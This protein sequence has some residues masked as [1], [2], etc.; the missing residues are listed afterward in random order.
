MQFSKG[1]EWRKW[2]LHIHTPLS[3][4]QHYGGDTDEVWEE[5]ISDL[6]R[7]PKEFGAIGINDYLFIDGYKKVIDFK[8]AGRLKNIDLILP[9]LEFRLE[10]FAGTEKNLR[11]INFHVIFSNYI[12][13]ETIQ[14]QFINALSPKY[15]L[16]SG[17]NGIRWSGIITRQSVADLGQQIK[18]SI[19]PDK[20]EQ[21]GSDLEEGFNNLV[22]NEDDIMEILKD[23]SYFNKEGTS[24]YLTAVGKTEWESLKW[25]DA[26][27]ASKKDII[28]K[29]DF[30]FIS[31]ETVD[32]CL[33]AKNKL[34]QHYV[35]D[36]LLDCSD[37]HSFSNKKETKDRIGKCFTWIK[38]D[39]IF[40]GLKYVI[41]DPIERVR[42]QLDHPSL[43]F[44]KPYFSKIEIQQDSPIFPQ[45]PDKKIKFTATNLDLNSGL[46]AIIGG[47]GTGKSILLDAI[48]ETFSKPKNKNR[49]KESEEITMQD[50][51]S[52]TYTKNSGETEEF[53]IGNKSE[54]VYLHVHQREVHDK[55]RDPELLS[56]TILD[57][58][59]ISLIEE[60]FSVNGESIDDILAQIK[61]CKDWLVNHD[62][63]SS[64]SII[65]RREQIISTITTDSNK[66][67]LATYA[68]NI[69]SIKSN[70]KHFTKLNNLKNKL[71]RVIIELN[72]EIQS[73]NNELTE[74]PITPIDFDLQIQNIE[75]ALSSLSA[76]SE[77]FKSSN[78]QIQQSLEEEKIEG[79]PV[80]LLQKVEEY[81]SDIEKAKEVIRQIEEQE[82]KLKSLI[83]R[84]S[85]FSNQLDSQLIKLVSHVDNT[86]AEKSGGRSDWNDQQKDLIKNLLAFISIHG[87]IY[88][89]KDEFYK[90]IQS[91][92]NG[93]KFRA[94]LPSITSLDRIKKMIPVNDYETYKKLIE[95]QPLIESEDGGLW[96]LEDFIQEDYFKVNGSDG[97][98]QVL[99]SNTERNG[100]LKV[101]A[102]I[103]YDEKS[104]EELSIGQR[105]TLYLCLKL[106]TESFFDPII[107]DQ[108]EDDL[109]NEF[110][111]EK[112]VPIFTTIKKYRQVIIATHNAN[113]VVNADAEQ[114]IVASNKGE[115]LSYLSGSLESQEIRDKICN[116]LEGGKEAFRKREQ[117]YGFR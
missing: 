22:L 32:Q 85:N 60:E 114:V 89:D 2:D 61:E 93:A 111:M 6:E 104:P 40:E 59:G 71:N 36:L 65:E 106:A 35:N 70:E 1:S 86:W 79:D 94:K 13:L 49:F 37:A 44:P 77:D 68:N 67:K 7:L 102:R 91:C 34:K 66:Q 29:A 17:A 31:S 24:L 9:V 51:F 5:F 78:L 12:E 27:I 97:F 58:L 90:K 72:H 88:F 4:V 103:K 82:N 39:A 110:I 96:T 107:I 20:V 43:E 50:S 73:V 117:K 26:S 18:L 109:D 116:V 92:L 62:K 113:L 108:P 81:R 47:R 33:N 42:I 99:F 28:N 16:T 8:K 53:Q 63:T 21:F 15:K 98:L 112:L 101:L 69:S 87:E 10:K 57:M 25:T 55:V 76:S 64:Q 56:T 100:Y 23:S 30:V 95:N 84:R 74:F 19:P 48:A 3:I 83:T 45:S 41:H 14:G 105:G 54:V 38:A 46:V 52:I 115:N 80:T 11:R 75:D